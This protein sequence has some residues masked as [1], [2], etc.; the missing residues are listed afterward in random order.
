MKAPFLASRL[1]YTP[2]NKSASHLLQNSSSIFIQKWIFKA[3]TGGVMVFIIPLGGIVLDS[4]LE[5]PWWWS[6]KL[7]EG[8][9][10]S[11]ELEMA[12]GF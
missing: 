11:G 8:R 4:W 10:S 3:L 7:L 12:K 1:S 9:R 6:A 2:P 5:R